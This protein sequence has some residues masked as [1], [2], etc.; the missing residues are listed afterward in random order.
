MDE[1]EIL[2]LSDLSLWEFH[3]DFALR[4]GG[5]VLDER[6][7]LCYSGAHPLPAYVNGV[8]RTGA[9]DTADVLGQADE[10]FGRRGRGYTIWIREHADRDLEDA[11]IEAGLPIYDD[12]PGMVL[13]QRIEDAPLPA[14]VVVR[15]VA[16]ASDASDFATV[17]G[18]AYASLGMREG[19]TP[20]LFSRLDTLVAPH[21][22]ALVAYDLSNGS[23][24][25]RTST[26]GPRP[27][28]ATLVHMNHGVALL[29]WVG[30]V[31][32]A[33]GKGLGA[34][35]TRMASNA[36]FDAGCHIASLQATEMGEPVYRR[37]GYREITRYRGYIRLY[38]PGRLR[39]RV[40][41]DPATR[42]ESRFG[43]GR[44]PDAPSHLIRRYR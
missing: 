37:L 26:A 5:T 43:S 20:V 6:G 29:N 38:E 1:A 40:V 30:T 2:S 42:G 7:L 14:G 44:R 11:I 36:G 3:R 24:G 17:A 27:V 8:W 34:A 19:T 15:R 18:T 33:R 22:V 35:M 16:D 13:D 4:G 10:F 25:A 21:I 23:S 41:R 12:S 39:P 32:A 31:P 28:A 9:V